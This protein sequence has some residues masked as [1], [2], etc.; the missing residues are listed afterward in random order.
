M[1]R[2]ARKSKTRAGESTS[3]PIAS[4]WSPLHQS[5]FRALWIATIVSNIGSW[6]QD[7][8]E[9]WLMTSLTLSP[10]LVALVETAGNLPVVLAALPAGALA[11]II[12]RRRLLL[13]MQA[14]MGIVAAA[15]GA[16]ALMGLMTPGRLLSLTFLLGVGSAV[17]NPAWQA[18]VPELVPPSDLPAAL[19]LSGVAV[20]I[21]RAIGP[22]VGGLIVAASGPWAVFLIN[23]GSFL[24]VFF[25][26]YRWQPAPRS[27]KLPPEE[28]IS[29][30]RAGTRYLRHSPELQ[31]VLIRCGAFI[32]CASALWAML[33]Q[34]ARRGLGLSSFAYG[35]LLGCI[36][37]GAIAGAWLL[38]R[39]R[40]RIAMNKLVA[41][42]TTL[43][44]L[45]MVALAYVHSF[46]LLA[47]AL[48]IGGI[49]WI[50]V[51][52]ALNIAAQ[53]ATPSWVR[54][55]VMAIYLLVFTG[56]LAGGSALWGFIAARAGISNALSLSA[57]GLLIGLPLM[58]RY[59]LVGKKTFSLTPSMHWPEPIMM[60][61][62]DAKE[63]P[64]I[65]SI[66]YKIDPKT[67]EEF[68]QAMKE[69]KRIRLRD[70]AIRWNVLRDSA[71]PERYLEVFVTESWGE[72]LRQ[73]ER[74]TAEDRKIEQ[75]VQ[76]FHL[77]GQPPRTTHLIA[78]ELPK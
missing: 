49:A 25:V 76:A 33:P 46:A 9:S 60:I 54:A 72:H 71:D 62:A 28:I 39:I 59:R 29:A 14:W 68:L 44:A 42:G 20:N 17:S 64:A 30:M 73:H 56:G 27:S 26:V 58:W 7:L 15:M 22:A 69:L 12:D 53:T 23:A 4:A 57:V 10:L 47:L 74:I 67:G 5:L 40:E 3:V 55:R 37:F 48:I 1:A 66:E 41:A 36:G 16:V 6:M 2:Q 18:I 31:T 61:D 11:D 77:G 38:P 70:G 13:F 45:A 8:G 78:E 32:I 24:A 75:R 63:G 21:A 51:L 50:S 52:S 43:F 19:S 65:T 34:Q 35:V